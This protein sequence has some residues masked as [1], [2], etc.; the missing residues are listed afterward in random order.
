VLTSS[1]KAD[2]DIKALDAKDKKKRDDAVKL[3]QHACG[4]A[5]INYSIHRDTQIAIKELKQESV[6]ADLVI[7]N[8]YETFT[9]YKEKPPTRFIKDLLADVQCPVL[10]VPNKY[11]S[12]DKVVLLYDGRPTSLYAAKMF[13]YLFSDLQ[14]IP[15]E[16]FTVKD[17]YMASLNLPNNKLM[18]EFIKRHF[19]N[20]SYTVVKGNVEEAV[21]EHLR[22][23]NENELVVAGAYQRGEI[24]R[25][26]RTSI[27]DVLMK[28][29]DTPLF[30]AHK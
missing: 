11:K 21:L 13:S 7:I 1:D 8:E 4:K 30:I 5:G 28:E 23:H 3:F 10:L 27:A 14:D 19:K 17:Y 22:N 6:F 26:F 9:K 16:V 20:A 18:R 15:V 29:I 24:S 2:E 12:I 25:F